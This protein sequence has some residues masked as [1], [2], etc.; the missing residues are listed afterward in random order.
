[1]DPTT[2]ATP[3][4]PTASADGFIGSIEDAFSGFDT[5]FADAPDPAPLKE[6]AAVVEPTGAA[7]EEPAADVEDTESPATDSPLDELDSADD[8]GKDWTPQAARRFKQLKAELKGSKTRL[9]ELE[10]SLSAREARL[11]ELEAIAE[12]PEY[13]QLK[14]RV[15]EYEQQLLVTKLESSKIYQDL[16]AQPLA[17]LV[18]EAD[19]I[20]EKYEVDANELLD[21][22][23]LEDEA[24]QEEALSDLLAAATDRDRFR[25]YKVIEQIKPILHQRSVLQENAQAALQEAEALQETQTKQQLAERAAAR[26]QAAEVV[27]DKI[28]TKLTFLEGVEGVDFAA[29][30]KKVAETDPTALSP[31][32]AAFQTYAA[33]LFP[34]LARE[35]VSLQKELSTLTDKLAKFDRASPRAGGGG[36]NPLLGGSDS[37]SSK[38]F[39]DAVN[40]AFGG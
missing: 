16:V 20:A 12:N 15:E 7:T 9:S 4:E 21:A 22:I 13:D 30:S 23:A 29:L 11:K 19:A 37:D 10:S 28:R 24:A 40:A 31:V 5:Q 6:A 39:A 33:Q 3:A 2:T 35:Y 32:D 8:V 25:I 17:E 1:M 14:S 27:A 34:K 38:S 36:S 18:T 26:Q